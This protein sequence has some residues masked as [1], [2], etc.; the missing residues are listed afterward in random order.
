MSGKDPH[1]PRC[2]GVMGG[3]GY[4]VMGL[5]GYGGVMGFHRRIP[6]RIHRRIHRTPKPKMIKMKPLNPP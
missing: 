3:G 6:R 4:G 5:W 1:N 2:Y